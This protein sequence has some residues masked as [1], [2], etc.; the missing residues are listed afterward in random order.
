MAA[1]DAVDKIR[2]QQGVADSI[3]PDFHADRLQEV[4]D[5]VEVNS[6]GVEAVA[7][8]LLETDRELYVTSESGERIGTV[9]RDSVHGLILKSADG[10]SK[11]LPVKVDGSAVDIVGDSL[12]SSFNG[13]TEGSFL[14]IGTPMEADGVTMYPLNAVP[15]NLEDTS[16]S[17]TS[18]LDYSI[19]TNYKVVVSGTVAG[20]YG[21]SSSV[22]SVMFTIINTSDTAKDVEYYVTINGVEAS[23]IHTAV[24]PAKDGFIDGSR[25]ISTTSIIPSDIVETDIVSLYVKVSSGSG[26]VTVKGTTTPTIIKVT[27]STDVTGELARMQVEIDESTIQ[28]G[29]RDNIQPFSSARAGGTVEPAWSDIGNG[30]YAYNFSVGDEMFTPFH[31]QHD[32]AIGTKAYPHVHFIVDQVMTAGQQIT[33]RFGYVIARGHAQGE[34]LTGAEV[35]FDVT[36]TATGTEIAGEHIVLECSDAQAF[37]LIEPDT[38][39]MMRFALLSENVSGS[40]FGLMSDLHY[41]VNMLNTANKAPDFYS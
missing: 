9:T 20:A 37:D 40:I 7:A 8:A 24:L 38:I 6:S 1:Q 14:Q 31:V 26:D 18:V 23:D 22:Y 34:S 13:I 27:Q 28:L 17:F 19:D 4:V 2:A 16:E 35:S 10:S 5:V 30:M 11:A 15:L 39:V 25:V 21:V 36:Y 41:Q 32:Y 12:L 3:D 33:W 29:W